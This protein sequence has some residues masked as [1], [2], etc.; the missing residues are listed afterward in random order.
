MLDPTAIVVASR[1]SASRA[2]SAL[3]EAPV[4]SEPARGR[5]ARPKSAAAALLRH[6]AARLDPSYEREAPCMPPSAGTG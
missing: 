2:R 5:P 6:F 4:T 1:P 3:P